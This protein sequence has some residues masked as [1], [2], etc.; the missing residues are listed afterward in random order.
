MHGDLVLLGAGDPT[1]SGRAYPYRAHPDRAAT[2]GEPANQDKTEPKP[3]AALEEMADQ[4]VRSGVRSV[5]GDI[6]G[7]DTFFVNEPYGTGWSWDDL[8]WAYGAPASALSVNDNTVV[9][10]LLPKLP[11]AG[12]ATQPVTAE[13]TALWSPET[14]W[15]TLEGAMTLSPH[16]VKSGPGLDRRPGSR[17]IRVWGTAPQEG[18]R[19]SLA[20]DD[21]AEYAAKSLMAM[22][23]GR[24]ITVS[25]TARARAIATS[26]RCTPAITGTGSLQYSHLLLLPSLR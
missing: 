13:M 17:V 18:F 4:I 14:P 21:P 20:I 19:T 8:Q 9:L 2:P 5:E 1:I 3:L 16:G 7:D 23:T 24:G 11:A 10:H 22:L 26:D 25:G 15:Y 6:V 12:D